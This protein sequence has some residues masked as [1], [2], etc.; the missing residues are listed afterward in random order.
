VP[1]GRNPEQFSKTVEAIA[2]YILKEYKNGMACSQTIRDMTPATLEEPRRPDDLNDP[3]K[4]AIFNEE[5]REYV[6]DTKSFKGQL[7]SAYGLILGQCTSSMKCAIESHRD[8]EAFRKN[9][10][11]IALLKAIQEISHGCK[12]H[13]Y[14]PLQLYK[15][16][17]KLFL[18]PLK[19][20]Q[21]LQDYHKGFQAQLDVIQSLGGSFDGRDLISWAYRKDGIDPYTATENQQRHAAQTS[22]EAFESIA[23]LSGADK[24]KYGQ[25][26]DDLENDQMKNI[27]SFPKTLIDAYNFLSRWK[28]STHRHSCSDLSNDGVNFAT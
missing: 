5:V 10:D 11:P 7:N 16:K 19:R 22:S 24:N 17:R 26:F 2:D 1:D 27:D 4:L 13:Q 14:L 23:F 21:S 18:L 8:Y 25:M 28:D 3:V 15:A 12:L 20:G 6:K 9:G